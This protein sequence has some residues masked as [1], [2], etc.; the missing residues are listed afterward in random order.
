M[1]QVVVELTGDEAKLLRSMQKVIEQN[2]KVKDSFKNSAKESKTASEQIN[3]H[4]TKNIGSLASMA[5]GYVS[6]QAATNLVV[7]VHTRMVDKQEKALDLARQLAKAQQEAAKN[8]AGTDRAVISEF[9]QSESERIAINANFKDV[10]K[11]SQTIGSVASIVGVSE[12][13][14]ASA[15][16]AAAILNRLTPEEMQSSATSIADVMKAGQIETGK[17]AAAL[18]LSTGSVSR[19]EEFA[20][21]ASAASRAIVTGVAA[22][23]NQKPIEAAKEAAAAFSLMS[24]VDKQGESGATATVGFI[25]GVAKPFSPNIDD[26]IKRDERIAELL[27]E[28]AVTPSEQIVIDRAMLTVQQKEMAARGVRPEDRSIQAQDLRLDLAEAKSALDRAKQ[29]ATLNEADSLELK[30]L[31]SQKEFATQDPGTLAT[32]IEAIQ[33]SQELLR[34]VE[35]DMT[36]EAIFKPIQKGLFQPDSIYTKDFQKALNTITTDVT[37]FDAVVESLTITPQQKLVLSE[38]RAATAVAVKRSADT[39]EANIAAAARIEQDALA[40]TNRGF[41]ESLASRLSGVT[42]NVQRSAASNDQEFIDRRIDTLS[43]RLRN[44]EK[45]GEDERS[46]QVLRSAIQA[47][48]DLPVSKPVE[49]LPAPKSV[50]QVT[51]PTSP[52]ISQPASVQPVVVSSPVQQVTAPTALAPQANQPVAPIVVPTPPITTQA[53]AATDRAVLDR[54]PSEQPKPNDQKLVDNQSTQVELLKKQNELMEETN[55]LLKESKSQTPAPTPPN[56]AAINA[57]TMVGR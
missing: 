14:A 2:S 4:I 44:F 29:S 42:A 16:E 31:Q 49:K 50:Q 11:I 18:L 56:P 3:S 41:M 35:S 25:S 43:N 26:T 10:P 21:L 51:A 57:Q 8:L 7:D 27:K 33:K 24:Q 55:R 9:I 39:P 22:S 53:P 37:A 13:V 12:K 54:M 19:P 46:I 48:R 34:T 5:A 20:K 6:V 15:V 45:S 23:P 28:Q 17:E 47:L 38:D 52:T 36:G 32:R 1:A 30:R 40:A